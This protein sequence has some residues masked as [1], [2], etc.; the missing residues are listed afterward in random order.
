MTKEE[1][2]KKI[3]ELLKTDNNLDFL[4]GLKKEDI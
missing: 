1:L 2:V 3:K 4:L